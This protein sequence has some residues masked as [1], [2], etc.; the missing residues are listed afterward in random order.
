MQTVSVAVSVLTLT[1]ISVERWYAICL[2][3]QFRSTISRAKKAIVMIWVVALLFDVPE[4]VV[5]ET[6]QKELAV[7]SV[8]LTQCE[9]TWGRESDMVFHC[10]KSAFLYFLPLGF[11]LIAYCQIAR[12]LWDEEHFPVHQP[13]RGGGGTARGTASWGRGGAGTAGWQVAA[14]RPWPAEG[15]IRSRRKAAKMLVAVV[16]LFAICYLPVH[17]LSVLRYTVEIPQ[18]EVTVACSLLSHWLC[19]ANSALNPLIYNFMSEKFRKEFRRT[20]GC[21]WWRRNVSRKWSRRPSRSGHASGH[22]HT[23]TPF[24]PG[25]PNA[26]RTMIVQL[27]RNSQVEVVPLGPLAALP[28]RANH[29]LNGNHSITE[30]DC[31]RC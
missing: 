21:R 12:V 8:L 7:K 19:Y 14:R 11:M 26:T 6:G 2:P 31:S 17:L 5:L 22:A 10:I 23:A 15:Q 3:L 25:T 16:A 30:L 4:L 18:T 27:G 13:G 1:F 20:F 29:H 28:P 9:P 24:T